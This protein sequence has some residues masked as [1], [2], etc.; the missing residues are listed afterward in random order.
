M[1]ETPVYRVR[2][3]ELARRRLKAM[4]AQTGKPESE[5]LELAI[6]DLRARLLHGEGVFL[7]IPDDPDD[8]PKSHK[9]PRRVA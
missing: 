8:G 6:T 9:R 5:I 7:T 4:S 3:N 1:P 2:L